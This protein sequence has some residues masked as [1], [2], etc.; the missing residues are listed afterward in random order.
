VVAPANAPYALEAANPPLEPASKAPYIDGAGAGLPDTNTPYPL[1]DGG[2]VAGDGTAAAACYTK[3]VTA[4]QRPH[5]KHGINLA[6][7]HHVV[8]LNS[9]TFVQR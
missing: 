7:T 5:D 3:H 9:A 4:M 8:N 2:A 6:S 1:A